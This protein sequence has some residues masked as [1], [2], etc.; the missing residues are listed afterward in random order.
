MIKIIL[1]LISILYIFISNSALAAGKHALLIGIKNYNYSNSIHSLKGPTNDIK[2]TKQVLTERFG[3]RYRDFIVIKDTEATHSGIERAF[4]KLIRRVK[5]NDF[6]YIF[7]SGHGSQTTDFNRD[8]PS[9]K[10]Q[11][12]VSYGARAN[13][14]DNAIDNYD[15]L[16]DEINIWLAKLYKKTDQVVFVSDSCH[17]ATVDRGKKLV[18]AVKEDKRPHLFAKRRYQRIIHRGIRIGAAKDNQSAIDFSIQQGIYYGLFNWYWLQNLNVAQAGDTWNDVFKR[19]YAQVTRKRGIAQHPQLEGNHQ[20]QILD[21]GFKA[22]PLTIPIRVAYKNWVGIEAGSLAGVTKGS[23]FR[24]YRKSQSQIARLIIIEVTPYASYGK[25]EPR[26]S[27]QLGDLVIAESHAYNFQP[28]KGDRKN[29][30][31]ELK[32]LQNHRNRNLAVSLQTSIWTPAKSN[33][34]CRKLSNEYYCSKSGPYNLKELENYSFTQG[35]ALSFVVSNQSDKD[36]YYYLINIS[37]DAAIRAIFPPA[38]KPIEFARIYEGETRELRTALKLNLVGEETLKI[39]ITNKPI[40]VLLFEQ[41]PIKGKLRGKKLNPLEQLL[42]NAVHGK[43]GQSL[44]KID[45]WATKQ[46]SFKVRLN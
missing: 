18:R 40:D 36:Y 37:P 2:L 23:V 46:V 6:V 39:I 30:I 14:W 24:L 21:N 44:I 31:Y 19:T 5:R 3:F 7:Y 38:N 22:L 41:A 26:G 45:E 33:S 9:G 15:V 28:L 42:V 10:D 1:L 17:S 20:R 27:F 8:E 4:E 32:A 29:R 25:P 12:W 16:D 34:N 13:N 43:R 35:Q 11:T